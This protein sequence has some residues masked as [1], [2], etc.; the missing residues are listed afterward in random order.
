[1]GAKKGRL[2][3]A[4]SQVLYSRH[5]LELVTHT[6]TDQGRI[7]VVLEGDVFGIGT[8]RVHVG[9]LGQGIGVA[10]A[11]R[12]LLVV[13]DRVADHSVRSAGERAGTGIGRVSNTP[14]SHEVD[15]TQLRAQTNGVGIDTHAIVVNQ[16]A[17]RVEFAEGNA[18][19]PAVTGLT[20]A[21]MQA[22]D[23]EVVA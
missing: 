16:G 7:Q 13:H 3:A 4:Q 9:A 11:K 12:L 6:Y 21:G 10:Q 20:P 22:N 14:R 8:D 17:G 19:E 23:V 2:A 1:M 15:V 5:S 18:L